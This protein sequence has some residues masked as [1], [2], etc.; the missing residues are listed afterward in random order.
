[1]ARGAGKSIPTVCGWK[2]TG[3]V[4][5]LKNVDLGLNGTI[6]RGWGERKGVRIGIFWQVLVYSSWVENIVHGEDGAWAARG[7]V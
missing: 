4:P 1:M 6:R 5:P 2:E 3:E 7:L